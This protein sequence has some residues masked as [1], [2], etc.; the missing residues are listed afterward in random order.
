MSEPNGAQSSTKPRRSR[1]TSIANQQHS[2]QVPAVQ[3][4]SND[5][6]EAWKENWRA[7]GQSWRTEPEIDAER[8]KYLAERRA[9]VPDIEKGIYPFK[10]IRLTRADVEW[11]LATHE[12]GR[13]PVDWNDESQR[14][15]KGLDLHGA[16]LRHVDLHNLPLACIH[17]G[18]TR[19]EWDQAFDMAPD[20]CSVAGA[21]LESANLQDAHLEGTELCGVHLEGSN[22]TRAYVEG[23]DLIDAH[24]EGANLSEIHLERAHLLGAYLEG[25]NLTR[26]FLEET[27][28]SWAHLEAT[29][30]KEVNLNRAKLIE[31]N[32]GG[33]D[34]RGSHLQGT[35]LTRALLKGRQISTP[36]IER[37]RKW[38]LNFPA[39]LPP[40]DL[41]STFFD[42]TTKL[43]SINL[44]N[45]EQGFVTLADVD[46]GGVNL[47]VVDWDQ[48]DKLGDERKAEQKNQL[49]EYRVAIRANRQLAVVLRDQALSEQADYFAYRAQ[50]LQRRAISLQVL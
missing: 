40:A 43:D 36:D 10:D 20:E 33:A 27:D 15:R 42:K 37:V 21:H 28:F 8:Q 9:I 6:A 18:L 31:T 39:S 48:V 2:K 1:K 13:G 12:N 3:R 22:L 26:A 32:L 5:D 16:D 14:K 41:R 50:V 29:C 7:Q 17:G 35:D 24:L 34:L 11:L 45:K 25:A 23:A 46:W 19:R 44:G 49:D 38:K 47:G 30:L 4:P